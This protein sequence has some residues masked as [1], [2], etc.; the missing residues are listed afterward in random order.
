MGSLYKHAPVR[1]GSTPR[2][3]H[4]RPDLYTHTKR[5]ASSMMFGA[6]RVQAQVNVKLCR[7][8][9]MGPPGPTHGPTAEQI[10]QQTG[11]ERSE[12][13]ECNPQL[14]V[15]CAT[16]TTRSGGRIVGVTPHLVQPYY[17]VDMPPG[18]G[19]TVYTFHSTADLTNLYTG[20]DESKGRFDQVC[21][22]LMTYAECHLTS[23]V[24]HSLPLMLTGSQIAANQAGV[25]TSPPPLHHGNPCPSDTNKGAS[26][27]ELQIL[28]IDWP[29]WIANNTQ[30]D[31]KC[32]VDISGR[33]DSLV[34]KELSYPNSGVYCH[35]LRAMGLLTV[36]KED[37][38]V[39]ARPSNGA[40]EAT[41]S[42]LG[43]NLPLLR[44]PTHVDVA[45]TQY[46]PCPETT[47]VERKQCGEFFDAYLAKDNKL[48]LPEEAPHS[49]WCKEVGIFRHLV[50][51][52]ID[53][54]LVILYDDKFKIQ[55]VSPNGPIPPA[56]AYPIEQGLRLTRPVPEVYPPPSSKKKRKAGGGAA[57][58][59]AP[60]RKKARAETLDME[61]EH[62]QLMADGGGG[63]SAPASGAYQQQQARPVLTDTELTSQ[64]AIAASIGHQSPSAA[65]RGDGAQAISSVVVN[66]STDEDDLMTLIDEILPQ[67]QGGNPPV[68]P[69]ASPSLAYLQSLISDVSGSEDESST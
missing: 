49:A 34:L 17:L 36:S 39:K 54:Y 59:S 51:R 37:A 4:I 68:S 42:T 55:V 31:L 64:H 61:R 35:Q 11:L 32:L 66:S 33:V 25:F 7:G 62:A 15:L 57:S 63:S 24:R 28:P 9:P 26:L 50:F 18:Q 3:T 27:A 44:T 53:L 22:E 45:P 21:R 47:R 8:S 6:R 23:E 14:H 1:A 2:S 13:L 52:G 38:Q 46:I 16:R 20:F 5:Q 69:P 43:A 41:F 12:L 10:E 30:E 19:G 56:E 65:T 60:P 67:Q 29:R 58:S 40:L 48:Y